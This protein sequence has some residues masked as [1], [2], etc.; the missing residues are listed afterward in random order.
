MTDEKAPIKRFIAGA[1]CPRCSAMDKIKAWSVGDI[2]HRECVACG[3]HDS[4]DPNQQGASG[5][6]N[7]ELPT[8][9]NH[10]ED[11]PQNEINVVKILGPR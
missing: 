9:V 4:M 10:M 11:D 3:F 7:E 2:Q 8:R 6:L 1:V 5:G